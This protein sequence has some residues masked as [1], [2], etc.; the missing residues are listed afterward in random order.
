MRGGDL[1]PGAMFSYL[2]PERRVPADQPLRPIRRR[3]DALLNLL[4]P[5]FDAMYA[6]PGALR[7]RP[8]SCCALCCCSAS[9]RRAASACRWSSWTIIRR[10][11]D[12]AIRRL[13]DSRRDCIR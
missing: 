9:I 8:R 11:T 1:Q 10:L 3:V 6:K 4:S 2:S 7:S 5:R 13:A 12:V